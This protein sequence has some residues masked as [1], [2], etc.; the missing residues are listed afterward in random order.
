M[1]RH[2]NAVNSHAPP[3]Y[4]QDPS[5][6][7]AFDEKINQGWSTEKI[8]VNLTESEST[9]SETIKNRKVIDNRKYEQ[10][11]KSK[12]ISGKQLEAE[13]IDSYLKEDDAFVKS[14]TLNKDGCN[15]L[16]FIQEQL[17]DVYHFCIKGNGILSIATMF[18]VCEG[19]YLTDSTCQNLSL[20]DQ[21]GK[22]FEFPGP[23]FWH[24]CKTGETY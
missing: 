14:L 20:V 6:K 12:N 15:T 21:S 11:E 3:Y 17:W 19:L 22:H 24:F 23:S 8:Y 18:E 1:P 4:W 9:L 13:I 7:T 16:Y 2:G 5:L 10:K